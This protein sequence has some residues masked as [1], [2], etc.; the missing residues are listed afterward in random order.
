VSTERITKPFRERIVFDQVHGQIMDE[1]RRYMLIRPE[2]LMGIFTRLPPAD[3]AMAMQALMASIYQQ[4]SDSA[5]AYQRMGNGDGVSLLRTVEATAP[6]L[7]WGRWTFDLKPRRLSL[8]VN[9]SPFA[10]G[11]GASR[12]PVCHAITGMLRAVAGIVFE[13]PVLAEEKACAAMGAPACL[14]EAVPA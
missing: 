11:Y 13:R 10:Q 5:K 8:S 14:F 7:G 1:A 4:G 2:A 9:N 12:L 6:D 3:A